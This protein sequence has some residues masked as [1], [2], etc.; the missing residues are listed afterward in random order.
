MWLLNLLLVILLSLTSTAQAANVT[1]TW[2]ANTE[3]DLAGYKIYQSTISGQYGAPVATLGK[4]TSTTLTL[5]DLQVD[6]TYFFAITAYDL[7]SNESGKSSEV[8][9]LVAAL[10]PPPPALPTPTNFRYDNGTMRWDAMPQATGGYY[11]RVHEMGTPY[12]PCSAMLYCNDPVGTLMATSVPLTFKPNT[13]YD[14]WVHSVAAD[15]TFGIAAG[16]QFTTP[17]APVDLPPAP[18]TGFALQVSR[19]VEGDLVITAKA[20]DCRRVTTS[21][22]GSTLLVSRRT[23]RCVK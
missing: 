6:A 13:Q 4:V 10:P 5:P 8:S 22:V 2:N 3:S 17:A 18:P 9:K 14:A 7:A 1:L 12:D 20:S 16:L 23:V 21:T 19:T 11:L 15:G